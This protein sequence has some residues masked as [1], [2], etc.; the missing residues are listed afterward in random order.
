VGEKST[1]GI[2]DPI[3][4]KQASHTVNLRKDSEMYLGM[5][6][7]QF[8]K[9]VVDLSGKERARVPLYIAKAIH[10]FMKAR[11]RVPLYIAK[12]I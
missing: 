8:D 7:K 2:I 11:A 10:A 9:E 1:I 4:V 12:K 5:T 6:M 3:R